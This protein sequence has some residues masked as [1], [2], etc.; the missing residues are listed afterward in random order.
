[1]EKKY[2]SPGWGFLAVSVIYP[3]SVIAFELFTQF[4]AETFFDPM[5]TV[6]HVLLVLTVPL[7]NLVLW[8]KLR[9]GNNWRVGPLL[10]LAAVS[11]GI[12]S[13]YTLIFLPLMPLSVIAIIFYG[14]GLLPFA[15][16]VALVGASRI[17]K[18]TRLKYANDV[19]GKRFLLKGFVI[20]LLVLLSL[21]I[22]SAATYLGVDW[23]LSDSKNTR[24]RGTQLLRILGDEDLL[25]RLSYDGSRR[26]TG[27]LSFT[28]LHLNRSRFVSVGEAREVFYRV[29]GKPFNVYPVPYTGQAWS[30][31]DGLRFDRDQG[32]T[33]VGGRVKGLE[34]ITSKIDGSISGDDGV[35]YLEWTFEFKNDSF[36][37][38]EVRLQLALPPEAV[39]SRATLWVNGEEREAAFAGRSKVRQAY[40]SVV[41]TRKDPLLVTTSGAD[42]VLAQAFPVPAE[43][44][45]IK[46]RIGL[47]APL[48][49]EQ[50]GRVS[51]VLPSIIDRNFNIDGDVKHAV[52]IESN[53]VI[54]IDAPGLNNQQINS[55]LFRI[56]GSISDANLSSPRKQIVAKRDVTKTLLKSTYN[57]SDAVYQ[58]V[59]S[60]DA[61]SPEALLIVV[62]G[63]VRVAPNRAKIITALDTIPQ[64]AKVG[65]MIASDEVVL[66]PI[67]RWSDQHRRKIEKT[68][69]SIKFVGGQDNTLA[70]SN[71]MQALE[72]FENGELLWIHAPQPVRFKRSQAIFEQSVSRLTRL[73]RIALYELYPGPNRVLDDAKVSSLSRTVPRLGSVQNDLSEY[74]RSIFSHKSVLQF[75]RSLNTVG[76][77]SEIV[78]G[79]QHVARIWANEEVNARIS[80]GKLED[81]LELATK[82]QLVTPVSGAV[83]L[84]NQQQYKDNDL[85]PVDEGTVPTIPEPHQWVLIILLIV[86]LLWFLKQNKFVLIN[87]T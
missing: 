59:V 9:S 31:F 56:H 66:V 27:L 74:M 57:N 21:D 3:V 75:Q 68:L 25:L 23:A 71:A 50:K 24:E 22:P 63:S 42:R 65:L 78:P 1:M 81:A 12:A 84:E 34:L 40:Q 28:I 4:C 60:T 79:S 69:K 20:S 70:L 61:K 15:P 37:Q 2:K 17:Y 41:N 44:G 86:F 77:E 85:S 18:K 47:T 32:G 35:A 33:E 38:Q 55:G 43:G 64:G 52:W 5:P 10:L 46:F 29:T 16:L 39:I 51:M 49:M 19:K 45:S 53:R 8:W 48:T 67:D 76:F 82:F 83:V 62:D 58:A 80:L 7:S 13:Y 11:I 73:P 36:S 72:P 54:E 26:A 87:K 30:R 14:M 6:F